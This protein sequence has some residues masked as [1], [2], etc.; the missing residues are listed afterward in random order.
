MPKYEVS[1]DLTLIITAEN[2]DHIY[3]QVQVWLNALQS[4]DFEKFLSMRQDGTIFPSSW[5][6]D[7]EDIKDQMVERVENQ[8][9]QKQLDEQRLNWKIE[10]A[11]RNLI[12]GEDE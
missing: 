7:T 8:Q 12:Q 6:V 5:Q 10:E 2:Q 11:G 3:G 1:V 4:G 9:T